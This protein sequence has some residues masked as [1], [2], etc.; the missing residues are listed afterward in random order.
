[1][2]CREFFADCDRFCG[3]AEQSMALADG[4]VGAQMSHHLVGVVRHRLAKLLNRS[5][6]LA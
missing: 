6:V 2:F 1:M 5:R 3:L 4:Q